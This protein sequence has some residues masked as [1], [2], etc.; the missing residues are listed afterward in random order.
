MSRRLIVVAASVILPLPQLLGAQR[1]TSRAPARESQPATLDSARYARTARELRGL[2][3]RL[4]GPFRG[5]RAVAVVGD[6]ANRNVFYFGSV[7]GGVWKT[8]NG[9]TSWRNVTDGVSTIA[10]VGA[11]AVAPSDP[12]VIYVGGGEADLREDWTYGDGMYRST[13]ALAQAPDGPG[14]VA[15]D[16][17]LDR[18]RSVRE[19]LPTQPPRYG[20]RS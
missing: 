11:I 20:A 14:Y 7:D 17:D 15:A 1:A 6:P 5:G 16:L 19:Q 13:D 18:V 10:S 4:V 3:W 12:N 9:G 8:T 2:R